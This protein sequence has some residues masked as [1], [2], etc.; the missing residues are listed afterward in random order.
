MSAGHTD[1]LRAARCERSIYH[2]RAGCSHTQPSERR[3]NG[4]DHF[5]S[6]RAV[7]LHAVA[8]IGAVIALVALIVLSTAFGSFQTNCDGH[9]KKSDLGAVSEQA[10]C[11]ARER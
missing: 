10:H 3:Q 5:G 1:Q 8:I 7:S 9:H 11:C 4:E 6:N 2:I